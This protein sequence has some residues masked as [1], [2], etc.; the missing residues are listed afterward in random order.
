MDNEGAQEE[1]G[2][3]LYDEDDVCE[4]ADE[5]NTESLKRGGGGSREQSPASLQTHSREPSPESGKSG[6]SREHSPE[7]VKQDGSSHRGQSPEHHSLNNED[8]EEQ[9]E[10]FDN[11]DEENDNHRGKLTQP[12]CESRG[13]IPTMSMLEGD[14]RTFEHRC[15][16]VVTGFSPAHFQKEGILDIIQQADRCSMKLSDRVDDELSGMLELH[17]PEPELTHTAVEVLQ[18][19]YTEEQ[20]LC[21]NNSASRHK[22]SSLTEQYNTNTRKLTFNPD[23]TLA[24]FN[25]PDQLEVE[26]ISSVL[27]AATQVMIPCS[28]EGVKKSYAFVEF[29]SRSKAGEVLEKGQVLV[30]KEEEEFTMK[31]FSIDSTN[32]LVPTV[33]KLLVQINSVDWDKNDYNRP[34]SSGLKAFYNRMLDHVIY[35]QKYAS[36]TEVYDKLRDQLSQYN[37][38]IRKKLE[39]ESELELQREQRRLQRDK[40]RPKNSERKR[41]RSHSGNRKEKSDDRKSKSSRS[42]KSRNDVKERS[43]RDRERSNRDRSDRERSR[44]ET[45]SKRRLTDRQD[46]LSLYSNKRSRLDASH[47]NQGGE[48]SQSC[49]TCGK[50]GHWK[51]ECPYIESRSC[52]LCGKNGHWKRECPSRNSRPIKSVPMRTENNDSNCYLCGKTGHYKRECPTLRRQPETNPRRSSD[53][54]PVRRGS[55]AGMPGLCHLC[56]KPGH[57]KRECPT[58]NTGRSSRRD[59]REI[60]SRAQGYEQMNGDMREG[61]TASALNLL[62]GLSNMMQ[63]PNNNKY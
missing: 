39:T 8:D 2:I 12:D 50:T 20:I 53:Q 56:G 27:P 19:L 5:V 3:M 36:D 55:D 48:S 9:N 35:F 26:D 54:G 43:N 45:T 30:T 4:S 52:H 17:Y 63:K 21:L 11:D 16:I 15:S 29:E 14:I 32:S 61:K 28:E 22:Y 1:E 37:S 46:E 59:S 58:H 51:M 33:S 31:P 25:L 18:G 13:F 44:H 57:W 62:L 10:L 7:S 24:L 41:D 40:D 34:M 6:A 60:N 38:K 47:D 49:F 23:T 42:T